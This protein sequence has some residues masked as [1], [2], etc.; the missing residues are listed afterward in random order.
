MINRMID[1]QTLNDLQYVG[2]PELIITDEV[3]ID[4]EKRNS[5][6]LEWRLFTLLLVIISALGTVFSIANMAESKSMLAAVVWAIAS[7]S[8]LLVTIG[9]LVKFI[10]ER[11]GI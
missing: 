3:M 9:T 7:T 10:I 8:Y 2:F 1:E 6:K 4:V 11:L 5:W